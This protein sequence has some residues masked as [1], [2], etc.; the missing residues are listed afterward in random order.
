MPQMWPSGLTLAMT[1]TMT[2]QIWNLVY[3]NKNDPIA[4]KR[5]ANILIEL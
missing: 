5:K 2:F 3:L 4:M 1:L